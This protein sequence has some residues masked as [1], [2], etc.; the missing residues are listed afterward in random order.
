MTDLSEKTKGFIFNLDGVIVDTAKYHYIAWRRLADEMG[1]D[2]PIEQHE[3]L[4]SLS[5]MESL[6]KIL[7]W[8]GLYMTEAEKLHWADVKNNWYQAL[9][10]NM[11][12]DE[13]FPGVLSFLDEVRRSGGKTALSSASRN[14]RTVLKSTHLEPYFDVILDGSAARKS[15]PHPEC[16]L[17]AAT[18]LNMAPSECIVFDDAVLGVQAAL[19]GGFHIIGIGKAEYLPDAERVIPGFADCHLADILDLVYKGASLTMAD[20][21]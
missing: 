7:E 1:V 9:V 14:A 21:E 12:P 4:R 15:K 20:A 5:R 2:F 3:Q 19:N 16:F 8:G 10:A 18:A 6:E 11:T 13:V 17:L